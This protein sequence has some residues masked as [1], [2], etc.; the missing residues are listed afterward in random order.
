MKTYEHR[1][2]VA[3]EH[4][5]V[6]APHAVEGNDRI[7]S[8]PRQTIQRQRM[9]QLQPEQSRTPPAMSAL[10]RGA[11]T[12]LWAAPVVQRVLDA[13]DFRRS[14]LTSVCANYG[15]HSWGDGEFISYEASDLTRN[16]VHVHVYDPTVTGG[17]ITLSGHAIWNKHGGRCEQAFTVT[18]TLHG[19]RWAAALALGATSIAV[20]NANP[21][22]RGQLFADVVNSLADIVSDALNE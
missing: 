22:A 3:T 20:A 9:A 14:H 2:T 17:V 6:K 21:N 13:D 1:P 12:Q 18:A 19:D 11:T 16:S 4:S 8:S 7:A 5:G 10:N 15:I